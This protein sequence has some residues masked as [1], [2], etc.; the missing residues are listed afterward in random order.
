MVIH[1]AST[2]EME[3][4]K[5]P[6]VFSKLFWLLLYLRL[7][8]VVVVQAQAQAQALPPAECRRLARSRLCHRAKWLSKTHL[9]S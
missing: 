6:G 3:K 5:C 8:R 2:A 7:Q 1:V 4:F 9:A